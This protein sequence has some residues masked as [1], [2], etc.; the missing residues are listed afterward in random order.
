MSIE[1]Y[2]L[3]SILMI[4]L[5]LFAT[6]L[7]RMDLTA[8]F[9]LVALTLTGLVT[10]TQALS[11][12]SNSSVVVVWAMFI[13][14]AGLSR[15]G[16]SNLIGAQLLKIAGRSEARLIAVLMSMSALFHPS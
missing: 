13:L 11:G 6:G 4:A 14:S 15:T 5:V 10:P 1:L 12:F 7:I 8:L 3:A 2:L 16:I 9:V